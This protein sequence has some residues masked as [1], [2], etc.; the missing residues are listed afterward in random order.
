MAARPT[1]ILFPKLLQRRA[2]L[3]DCVTACHERRAYGTRIGF[4]ERV[5]ENWTFVAR[6]ARRQANSCRGDKGS[7]RA[8]ART[9]A[10]AS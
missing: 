4:V 2:I 6:A 7:R 9:V 1:A 10:P 3:S 8:I 5:A